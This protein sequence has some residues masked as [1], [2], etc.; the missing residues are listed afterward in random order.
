VNSSNIKK[1]NEFDG[2]L[3]FGA[4]AFNKATK[5]DKH[6]KKSKNDYNFKKLLSSK[7]TI[8]KQYTISRACPACSLSKK[9]SK[10]EF[11]K[12]GFEH[13]ICSKCEM[14]YVSPILNKKISHK[15]HQQQKSF[16]KVYDNP[17][18]IKMD[19]KK[20]LYGLNIIENFSIKKN[21]KKLLDIGC[22]M[23]GF[24]KIAKKKNWSAEGI[25]FNE[26]SSKKL[27]EKGYKIYN[28]YIEKLDLQRNYDCVSMW[29]LFEHLPNPTSM[30]KNIHKILLPKGVVFMLVP[31]INGL[32]NTILRDKAV[33]FA[34]YTHLNFFNIKTLT[35]LLKK[36][37]F[38]VLHYETIFTEI[39]TIKNYL[40]FKDPYLGSA[41]TN[42]NFF[43]SK[44][45]HENYLGSKL[46]MVAKK[47]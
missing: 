29:N 6:L 43:S 33:A 39:E 12:E 5:R 31:N 37:G 15:I 35:S 13:R 3:I 21:K 34:G 36:N 8:S 19:N 20:F 28:D 44:Y 25:E 30:L 22:G 41:P 26:Y 4:K 1:K 16:N 27:K 17:I 47:S 40:N 2:N 38:S 46:I 45:I 32:V 9:K 18:Q 24:I 11:I 23:G 7:K 42:P 10:I 14:F